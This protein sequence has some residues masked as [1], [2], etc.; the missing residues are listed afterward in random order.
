MKNSAK[1]IDPVRASRAGHS[2]HERWAARC[3]LRLVLPKDD[4]FAVVV[5]GFSP[6][7]NLNLSRAAEEIADLVLFYGNG[8]TLETCS[9]LQVLQFKYKVAATPVTSSYLKKTVKKFSATLCDVKAKISND[10]IAKKLS[11]VFVTNAEFSG[12]LR[13]AIS[14]L[15]SGGTP[16]SQGARRQHESLKLWCGEEGIR[17]EKL[18][19]LVKFRASTRDLPAQNRELRARQ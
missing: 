6:D 2:F 18:I 8:D 17:A 3:A 7:E 16:Q 19:P 15:Q 1:R 12:S 13:D 9:T 5:E 4:L 11:F 14:C 10:E